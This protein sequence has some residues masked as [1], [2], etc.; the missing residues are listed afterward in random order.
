METIK[1]QH[2]KKYSI[3]F[4]DKKNKDFNGFRS[5]IVRLT[6]IKYITKHLVI[7]SKGISYI[8]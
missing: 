3:R 5:V 2:L 8:I 1:D 7:Y 4:K 6:L